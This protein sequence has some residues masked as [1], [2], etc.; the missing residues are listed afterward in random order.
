MPS[1]LSTSLLASILGISALI[2]LSACTGK[3]ED[4][5]PYDADGDGI[6]AMADCDDDNP[7]LA[8]PSR[9]YE[10][11]DLDGFGNAKSAKLACGPSEGWVEDQTDCNDQDTNTHP[12]AIEYC[13]GT[14]DDCDSDHSMLEKADTVTLYPDFDGDSF[15]NPE[16]PTVVCPGT[17]GYLSDN[18][19]CDDTDETVNPTAAEVCVDHQDDDCNGQVDGCDAPLQDQPTITG[20]GTG[21]L[22]G[23]SVASAGDINDDSQGDLLIGAPGTGSAGSAWIVAGPVTADLDLSVKGIELQGDIDGSLA[24]W[25]VSGGRDLDMDLISDIV[26]GAPAS[27]DEPGRVY[28]LGGP[29]EDS[30]S[31]GESTATITG[32][33]ADLFGWSVQMSEDLSNDSSWDF[34][35]G[36]PGSNEGGSGAGAVYLFSGSVVGSVDASSAKGMVLGSAGMGFGQGL[37]MPR[38][39]SGD[40]ANDLVISAPDASGQTGKVYLFEGP[41]SGT[42]SPGDALGALE[43]ENNCDRAGY[44]LAAPGD[45]N[46]DG[47]HDLIVG[48][49]VND[50]SCGSDDPGKAYVFFGPVEEDVSLADSGVIFVGVEDG[51][52]AG[53]SLANVRDAEGDGLI[54][55]VIGA[56]GADSESGRAWLILGPVE[57]T[58]ELTTAHLNYLGQSAG[59]LAGSAVGA[60]GDLSGD[61]RQDI[62][63]GA[64]Q[65]GGNGE[66]YLYFGTTTW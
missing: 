25:S 38:D 21:S 54:D 58:F 23:T 65:A 61:T 63:I 62:A 31:L 30:L 55:F 16:E 49:P 39:L 6:Q 17:E 45:M 53:A 40:G 1:I 47:Y 26:I 10:D 11:A 57:G 15:G 5:G 43:G 37:T 22:I 41:I 51:D 28:V 46:Q 27:G 59:D 18:Q 66:V 8:T 33:S 2:A 44:A 35:V 50:P 13:D 9:F 48:A 4:T 34:I 56:P 14:G 42:L 19:D 36:A 52:Q 29:I 3:E 32:S 24:G 12:G 60:A 20:D 7:D 64:P